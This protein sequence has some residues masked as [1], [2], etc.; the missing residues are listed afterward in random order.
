LIGKRSLTIFKGDE[1]MFRKN[2]TEAISFR[3]FMA[4]ERAVKEMPRNKSIYAFSAFFPAITPS[5][6]FP[7]HDLDFALFV[8]GVGVITLAAFV[9][10][11][12]A[13]SGLPDIAYAIAGIGRFVFPVITYGTV[14]W[15]LFFGI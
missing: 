11:L 8:S 5:S 10:H 15:F 13:K 12:L 9:E 4:N 3:E 1:Y 2:K 14:F 6:L 7:I